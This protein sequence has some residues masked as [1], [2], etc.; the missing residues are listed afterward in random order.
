[1]K[2]FI[3]PILAATSVLSTLSLVNPSS[4]SAGTIYN[5]QV[6]Q[7]ERV[8]KGVQQGT[9]SQQEYKNLQARETKIAAQRRVYLKDGDL[10]KKEA[11]HLT[12]AQNRT[13]RAIYRDRHD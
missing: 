2:S 3:L 5:R 11:V 6:N 9:I 8:Y 13:S 7:Q 1:M 4:A 10:T 12:T